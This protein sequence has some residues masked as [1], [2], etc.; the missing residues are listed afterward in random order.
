MPTTRRRYVDG[1]FFCIAYTP[2]QLDSLIADNRCRL[3]EDGELERFCLR[4]RTWLPAD[5][6]FWIPSRRHIG[7]FRNWCRCCEAEAYMK[8]PAPVEQLQAMTA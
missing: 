2:A 5:T 7:G 8:R 1:P 4:C 6:Q 3:D